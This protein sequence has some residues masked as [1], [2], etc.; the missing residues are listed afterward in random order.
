MFNAASAAI[1]VGV[2]VLPMVASLCDDALRAVPEALRHGGYSL[3]ATSYEVTT[4]IV[5][6]AGLS[7]IFAAFVLAVSRAIGG[8]MAVTLTAGATPKPNRESAGIYPDNDR[9]Y[10]A[11][12]L[13]GHPFRQL[14]LQ[15]CLHV[16]SVLFVA[17]FAQS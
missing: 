9:L 8:T 7:G 5:V 12:K 15:A 2:M 4:R 17:P 10:S 13:G 3:G 11:S 1:V 6:P 14:K 16:A